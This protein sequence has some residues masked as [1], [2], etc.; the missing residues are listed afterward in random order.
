MKLTEESFTE[1]RGSTSMMTKKMLAKVLLK[2]QYIRDEEQLL[3]DIVEDVNQKLMEVEYAVEFL[4]A[5][6]YAAK[7]PLEDSLD[8][9]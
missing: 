3:S 7:N 2:M 4:N 1:S 8:Y 9:Q 5:M 6:E